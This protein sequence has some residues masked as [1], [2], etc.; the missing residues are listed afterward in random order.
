MVRE[1]IVQVSD[2][3]DPMAFEKFERYWSPERLFRCKSCGYYIKGKCIRSGMLDPWR[4]EDW[5]C[6]D[7]YERSKFTENGTVREEAR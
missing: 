3:L 6:A 2:E 5:F 1:Y 7:A 4:N